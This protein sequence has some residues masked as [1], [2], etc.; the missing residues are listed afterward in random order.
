MSTYQ[1]IV[2]S[3]GMEVQNFSLF[4]EVPDTS[5]GST[6]NYL[7]SNVY[8]TS[9]PI[10]GTPLLLD[11]PKQPRPNFQQFAVTT[12]AYAVCGYDVINEQAV[13]SGT[14]N[15]AV[16]PNDDCS[17]AANCI[18]AQG[19]PDFTAT[20]GG[21]AGSGGSFDIRVSPYNKNLFRKLHSP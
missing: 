21:A 1:I 17:D 10:Y 9:R 20:T 15:V 5:G 16:N 2:V 7:L 3:R 18:V 12:D 4:A 19:G 11:S 14:D 6:P 8:A 13:L